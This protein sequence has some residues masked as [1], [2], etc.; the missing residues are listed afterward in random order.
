MYQWHRSW[1][2]LQEGQRPS[3]RETP[4]ATVPVKQCSAPVSPPWT[5]EEHLKD[6][7]RKR[8]A[9]HPDKGGTHEEFLAANTEYE[10]FRKLLA[11]R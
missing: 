8:V 5:L 1:D 3:C 4:T 7:H 6:L 9:A 2:T 11:K 10:A